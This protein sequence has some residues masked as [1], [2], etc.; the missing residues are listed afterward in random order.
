MFAEVSILHR[1][2]RMISVVNTRDC[3]GISELPL[4]QLILPY[5]F[6]CNKVIL[7]IPLLSLNAAQFSF[8]SPPDL[9]ILDSTLSLHYRNPGGHYPHVVWRPFLVF[10]FGS[11]SLPQWKLGEIYVKNS[12]NLVKKAQNVHKLLIF[13]P[14]RMSAWML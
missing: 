6:S 14:E 3:N 11:I 8:I 4:I 2:Q 13:G 10:P 7:E 12:L 1:I 9:D 5:K